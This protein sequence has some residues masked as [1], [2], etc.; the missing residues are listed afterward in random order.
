M[1]KLTQSLLLAAVV[2]SPGAASHA[3]DE[4]GAFAIKGVGLT[5]CSD[6]VKAIREAPG[7][8]RRL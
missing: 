1:K 8:Q 4:N 3:A 2:S 7:P 6:F 5:R